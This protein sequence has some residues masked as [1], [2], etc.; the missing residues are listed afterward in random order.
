MGGG[1]RVHARLAFE[2]SGLAA[3]GPL[4]LDF[5]A[6]QAVLC[7]HRLHEVAAPQGWLPA[8]LQPC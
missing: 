5:G 1:P 8:S 2:A 4:S 3:H 6:P 7:A